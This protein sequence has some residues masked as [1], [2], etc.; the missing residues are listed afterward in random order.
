MA[1]SY[2]SRISSRSSLKS[3]KSPKSSGSSNGI[4]LVLG[5]LVILIIILIVIGGF[6]YKN[7]KFTNPKE[8]TL[9]YF[10][11][12]NC[13]YCKEFNDIWIEL[14]NTIINNPKVNTI[15]YDIRDEG[16]GTSAAELYNVRGAPTII[17]VDNKKKYY[18]YNG[19]RSVND[20][21]KFVESKSN[22]TT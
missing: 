15:K 6:Y 12:E 17:L 1:S 7:E 14:E 5:L 9:Q 20:I 4:W 16:V 22:I 8:F 13:G 3:S 21:M 2:K 18:E 10:Y 19:N 11:M